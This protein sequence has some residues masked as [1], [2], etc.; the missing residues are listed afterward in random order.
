MKK[1]FISIGSILIITFV[2][3]LFINASE[4]KK[5][6]AKAKTEVTQSETVEPCT[7]ACNNSTGVKT[8]TC[9]PE[10]CKEVN[11]IDDKCDPAT[12]PMHKEGQP[13][14]DQMCGSSVACKGSC[15]TATAESK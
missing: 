2:V 4:A 14:K 5:D 7:A 13:E 3:V 1:L 10:K 15:H 8:A 12:C 9:D 11:C 6:T